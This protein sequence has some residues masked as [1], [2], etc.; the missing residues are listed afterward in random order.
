MKEGWTY[1]SLSEIC[2]QITDGSHNPPVG[3]DMSNY[4]MLSSK[5]ISFDK[6]DYLEP[7]YLTKEQFEVE[8]KRTRISDG[9]VLLTIVGTVGRACC[10]KEPFNSFTVQRSVAVIKPRKEVVL[11][12]FLMYHFTALKEYFDK[13]AIGVA[14]KGIY[15]KQLSKLPI[16]LPPL[17]EQERIVA[18]LDLLSSIIDKQK[19][20]LKELD[21]LAQ[22]IF[23]D[24]FGNPNTNEKNW[25]VRKLSDVC[26][27]YDYLR[28][29]ITASERKSGKTP[30]YGASGIVDYV[31]GFIF[32]GDYLLVSEDGANL[33]MRHTPIAFSISGKTWVNN[34]AHI[35][36]FSNKATQL[37][38]E[39]WFALYDI[40][41]LLT[42]AVQPKLT[43]AKLNSV[44]LPLPPFPLQESFAKKIF[45]IESQKESINQ[46]IA[47]SQ[48]LFDYT[49]DKYFS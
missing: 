47:E 29:P 36:K 28:K 46:S 7:R 9:D 39:N 5:N 1:K 30:Y 18:E 26:I 13:E 44:L 33:E 24:M 21:A 41:D 37:F 25:E 48:K 19:A 34:H 16:V 14:Q 4:P 40:S 22:S 12:R 43:Q 3:V 15:L 23:Y 49:M 32:D 38:V 2:T 11:P 20:Q 8:N 10:V 45:A 35:L 31:E 42:G 27:N 17:A 6:F